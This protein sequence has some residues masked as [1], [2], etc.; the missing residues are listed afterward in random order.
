[1]WPVICWPALTLRLQ[2]TLVP[3]RLVVLRYKEVMYRSSV[4]N[5]KGPAGDGWRGQCQTNPGEAAML[6]WI[7][8]RQ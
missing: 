3:K 4:E 5:R 7:S 2:I 6:H 8:D 1:M